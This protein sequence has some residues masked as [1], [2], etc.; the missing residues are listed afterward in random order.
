M[1]RTEKYF[2]RYNEK[3]FGC[4]LPHPVIRWADLKHFGHYYQENNEHIIE[5][6]EWSRTNNTIWRLTLL[7]ELVHL[8]L[9]DRRCKLHG[10]VFNNE[11]KRLAN[12][13]AF[14]GLW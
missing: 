6:A 12:I 11:M 8:H 13:G 5:L 14:N 9:R 4:A 1:T 2:H 7:H 10:R 3:Y